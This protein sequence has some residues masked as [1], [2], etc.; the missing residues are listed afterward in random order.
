M[1]FWFITRG[2]NVITNQ[3]ATSSILIESRPPSTRLSSMMEAYLSLCTGTTTR[4]SASPTGPALASWTSTLLRVAASPA[5]SWTSLSTP[6]H[7]HSIS[8]FLTM[9]PHELLHLPRCPHSYLNLS[10]SHPIPPICY[11]PSSSQ[12][13]K[14]HMNMTVSFTRDSSANLPT[15]PSVSALSHTSI[16]NQKTGGF[17]YLILPLHG[18][19]YAWKASSFRDTSHRRFSTPA[20]QKLHP[21]LV[22]FI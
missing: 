20:A 11:H 14:S 3:T 16:R 13:V 18:R 15:A 12:A 7:P 1:P 2:T 4:R 19:T 5:R 9:G 21:M 8:S 22:Q 6:R 10:P 17:L